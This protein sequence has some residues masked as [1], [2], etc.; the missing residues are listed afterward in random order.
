MSLR[1]WPLCRV[2]RAVAAPLSPLF[3]ASSYAY[4]LAT[5]LRIRHRLRTHVLV[6][7]APTRNAS[8]HASGQGESTRRGTD[9][10]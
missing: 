2:A 3:Y 4:T 7:T 8:K 9:T 10:K 1:A 6:S 5:A